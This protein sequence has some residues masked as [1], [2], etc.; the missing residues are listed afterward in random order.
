[1]IEVWRPV[2]GEGSE[3]GVEGQ[4]TAISDTLGLARISTWR[5][6][7]FQLAAEELVNEH[8]GFEEVTTSELVHG[9]E[10]LT[11][12]YFVFR[13]EVVAEVVKEK[14]EGEMVMGRKLQVTFA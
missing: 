13:S 9:A 11:D 12:V 4:R 10:S 8:G 3:N 7:A 2:G 1:M 6:P 5:L 14:I